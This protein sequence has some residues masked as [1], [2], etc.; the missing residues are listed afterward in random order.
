MGVLN[1]TENFHFLGNKR[2][3]KILC[4][5]DWLIVLFITKLEMAENHTGIIDPAP[6]MRDIIFPEISKHFGA[7]FK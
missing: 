3:E 6:K 4:S 7:Y 2:D 1:A 5:F